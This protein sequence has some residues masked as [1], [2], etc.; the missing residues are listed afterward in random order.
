MA[1]RVRR[2]RQFS[3]AMPVVE[4]SSALTPQPA[5][6]EEGGRGAPPPRRR[7]KEKPA[8]RLP[9]LTA[10][11]VVALA[12]VLCAACFMS[13]SQIAYA[14]QL[15]KEIE[16]L[17]ASIR[18]ERENN[19][20]LNQELTEA[21]DGE[22]IRNYAVNKLGMIKPTTQQVFSIA[23]SQPIQV[24]EAQDTPDETTQESIDWLGVILG[25]LN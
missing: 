18:Q 15:Q 11:M 19:L 25:L 16:S 6:G 17:Q 22:M 1:E 5:W 4:G 24:N 9:S 21:T 3:Y 8:R 23:L 20:L 14:A 7:A 12:G 2:A 13:L 10:A